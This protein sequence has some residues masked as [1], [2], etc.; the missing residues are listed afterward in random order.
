MLLNDISWQY[1]CLLVTLSGTLLTVHFGI[2]G[3]YVTICSLCDG[4]QL[5]GID[6]VMEAAKLFIK[7]RSAVSILTKYYR[8]LQ[9]DNDLQSHSLPYKTSFNVQG[10][11]VRV[12]YVRKIKMS[13][14]S[15]TV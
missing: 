3:K 10:N 15:I 14:T 7:L 6:C 13:S 11:D 4:F 5:Q 8:D 9:P 1:P 12:K 2:V